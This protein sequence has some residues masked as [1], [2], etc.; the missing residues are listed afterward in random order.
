M[1]REM[2]AATWR[3][4]LFAPG[5]TI[6]HS[7]V[8]GDREDDGQ[9]EEKT[10]GRHCSFWDGVPDRMGGYLRERVRHCMAGSPRRVLA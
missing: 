6:S 7:G 3:E 9:R 5:A 1:A 10:E 4:E 2:H 8:V